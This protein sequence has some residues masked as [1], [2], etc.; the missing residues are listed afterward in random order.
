MLNVIRMEVYRMF[1]SVSFYVTLILC[2]GMACALLMIQAKSINKFYDGAAQSESLVTADKDAE[3]AAQT[4]NVACPIT[5]CDSYIA[6]T[7]MFLGIFLALFVGAFY[8]DGFAK[9][10]ISRVRHRYDFQGARAVCAIL[11][12]AIALGLTALST[13]GLAAVLIHTFTFTHMGEFA[14]FLLSK[15]LLNSVEGL[16]FA[17]FTDFF[18][19]KLP[20]FIY[21]VLIS[22]NLI[23]LFQFLVNKAVE[24][25]LSVDFHIED[26]LP[27]LYSVN[28]RYTGNAGDVRNLLIHSIIL[29]IG[30]FVVYNALGSLHF[31]KR[32]N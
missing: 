29:F 18:R 26:C 23:M 16:M 20:S 32:D 17:F 8:S 2:V 25:L 10:V 14:V 30:A 12:A 11:Y 27:S 21:A 9:N 1:H 28:Y 6:T 7:D 31:T 22:T 19:S 13:V 15:F 5:I 4:E 24:K 3:E